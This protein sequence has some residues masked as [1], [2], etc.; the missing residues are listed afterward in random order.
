[1]SGFLTERD[2]LDAH[3]QFGRLDRT[4]VKKAMGPNWPSHWDN[5][6]AGEAIFDPA[7]PAPQGDGE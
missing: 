3:A 7:P 4:L 5:I 6:P 1:M 2:V